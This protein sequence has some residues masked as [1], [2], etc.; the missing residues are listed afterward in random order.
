MIQHFLWHKVAKLLL[1]KIK[2]AKLHTFLK[3]SGQNIYIINVAKLHTFYE[4]KWAIY[5]YI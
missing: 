5:I 1:F 4:I 3:E 2:V